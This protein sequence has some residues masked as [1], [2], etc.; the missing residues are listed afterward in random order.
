MFESVPPAN[1]MFFKVHKSSIVVP[2]LIMVFTRL[3]YSLYHR[4][5]RIEQSNQICMSPGGTWLPSSSREDMILISA[6]HT[7]KYM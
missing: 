7:E 2:L 5:L 1:A 6:Y 3:H 4:S